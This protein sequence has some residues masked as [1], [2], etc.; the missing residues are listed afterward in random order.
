MSF[1][2]CSGCE[3]VGNVIFLPLH[4]CTIKKL[5]NADYFEDHS[6]DYKINSLPFKISKVLTDV[7][8]GILK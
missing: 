1:D 4:F 3:H 8:S 5:D 7:P 6:I 2:T